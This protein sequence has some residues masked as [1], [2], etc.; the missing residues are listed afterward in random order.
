MNNQQ[1]IHNLI[2]GTGRSGTT[3]L[4]HI[5]C[6][7]G[8]DF[9]SISPVNI[10]APGD[11]IGGGME[12]SSFAQVNAAIL[13][14][15]NKFPLEE[16]VVRNANAMHQEWPQYMK[17][18]RYLLTWPVWEKSN[19]R[20]RHIFFCTRNPEMTNQ[21]IGNTTNWNM[22]DPQILYRK[23]YECLLYVQEKYISHT[24]IHYPRIAK[25]QV[26]AEKVLGSLINDPWP[27]IQKTWDD[28]LHHFRS[29]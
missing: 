15:M 12:H 17:D 7:A 29:E 20:P 2:T 13:G 5:L 16:V 19:I 9:G 18:P 3:F 22:K 27:I 6:N 21:S 10:S 24:F 26:Y 1:Q 28:S 25:D 4:S 14:D 8:L 11:P 23:F